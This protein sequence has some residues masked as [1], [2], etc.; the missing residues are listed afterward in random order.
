MIW[1][2]VHSAICGEATAEKSTANPALL[3]EHQPHRHL[4]KCWGLIVQP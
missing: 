3:R 2:G 1:T 4:N